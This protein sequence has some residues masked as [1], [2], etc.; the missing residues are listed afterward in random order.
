VSGASF[1][2]RLDFILHTV[3][4]RGN[5][6][7]LWL[8]RSSSSSAISSLGVATFNAVAAI[9][10]I[11]RRIVRTNT[12]VTVLGSPVAGESIGKLEAKDVVSVETVALQR[13]DHDRRLNSILEISKTQHDSFTLTLFARNETHSFE[14]NKRSENVRYFSFRG[15]RRHTLDIHRVTCIFWNRQNLRF[16]SC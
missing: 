15:V 14:T 11:C 7:R 6:R 4:Q 3:D 1:A 10:A 2:I 12:I 9:S 16:V 8:R 13:V 5:Q